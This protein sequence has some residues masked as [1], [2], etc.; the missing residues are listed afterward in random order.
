MQN[1]N[2]AKLQQFLNAYEG[3]TLPVTGYFG[4]LTLAAVK[5]FQVK[6]WEEILEPWIP[7]G[8]SHAKAA[9]GYVYKT[10]Q[11]KINMIVCPEL[12]LLMPELP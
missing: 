9:T 7:Y 12:D 2:V 8:L 6:Y 10:T 4:P 1:D 5:R 3:E 11:R